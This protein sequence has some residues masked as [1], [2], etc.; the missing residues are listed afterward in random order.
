MIDKSRQEYCM[1]VYEER[2]KNRR[3]VR[4]TN[5][6]TT[7][8]CGDCSDN[9]RVVLCNLADRDWSTRFSVA[10]SCGSRR[11]IP[12]LKNPIHLI[13]FNINESLE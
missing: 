6:T 2:D 12:K 1:H 7:M 10:P 5:N 8:P 3:R 13:F 4:A 9:V 11:R